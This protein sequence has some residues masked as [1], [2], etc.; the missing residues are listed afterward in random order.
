MIIVVAIIAVPRTAVT[1]TQSSAVEQKFF[2][3]R[4]PRGQYQAPRCGA[5]CDTPWRATDCNVQR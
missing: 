4:L 2:V 1:S 3:R 5:T